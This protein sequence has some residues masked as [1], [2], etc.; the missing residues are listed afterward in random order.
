MIVRQLIII[1]AAIALGACNKEP[2]PASLGLTAPAALLKDCADL[3]S[4]PPNDGDK[5]VR[6]EYYALTRDAYA[7]CK[8]NNHGLKRFAETVT[9]KDTK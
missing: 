5:T 3:P 6:K 9:A 4:I 8:D 1:I 7:A 2:P